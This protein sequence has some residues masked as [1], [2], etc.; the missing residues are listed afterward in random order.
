MISVFAFT[1]KIASELFS[2]KARKPS[3]VVAAMSVTSNHITEKP[4]CAQGKFQAEFGLSGLN[5]D[6]WHVVVRLG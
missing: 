3:K 5:Q 4:F 6:S 2:I 1:R